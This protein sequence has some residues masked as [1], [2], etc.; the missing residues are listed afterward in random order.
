MTTLAPLGV[1]LPLI[2]VVVNKGKVVARYR[3]V[4]ADGEHYTH[5]HTMDLQGVVYPDDELERLKLTTASQLVE[6][7]GGGTIIAHGYNATM[8]VFLFDWGV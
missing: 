3:M 1:R 8:D 2:T 5:T 7:L 4:R 6:M